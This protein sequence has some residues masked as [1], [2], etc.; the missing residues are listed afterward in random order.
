MRHIV[1]ILGMVAFQVGLL[2]VALLLASPTF[3][4][5]IFQDLLSPQEWETWSGTFL[6]SADTTIAVAFAFCLIWY[7]T[8]Q[9]FFKVDRWEK[10]NKR[11]VWATLA[12]VVLFVCLVAGYFSAQVPGDFMLVYLFFV[13]VF[14]FGFWAATI[15]FSPSS[16]KYAPLLAQA[17]RRW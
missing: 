6:L 17:V 10:S 11:T 7:V 13:V 2:F 8:A 4:T 3:G 5:P 12:A 15:C 14:L 9:L 16:H 1:N